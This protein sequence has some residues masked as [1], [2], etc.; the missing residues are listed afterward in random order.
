MSQERPPTK[1]KKKKRKRKAPAASGARPPAGVDPV[2]LSQVF[3]HQRWM[4]LG[5]TIAVIG[6][7]LVGIGYH[8]GGDGAARDAPIALVLTGLLLLMYRIHRFG[9]LGSEARRG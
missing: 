5:A 3:R 1:K 2:A 6:L 9:R 7:A 4:A 8:E